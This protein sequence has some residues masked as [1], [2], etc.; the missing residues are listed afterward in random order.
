[1]LN[2]VV[3]STSRGLLSDCEIFAN[4]RIAFVSSSSDQGPGLRH[5]VTLVITVPK[6]DDENDEGEDDHEEEG[7][8][9]CHHDQGGLLGLRFVALVKRLRKARREFYGH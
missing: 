2:G 3:V 7:D 1:M 8:N 4:L 9:D 5:F 6:E